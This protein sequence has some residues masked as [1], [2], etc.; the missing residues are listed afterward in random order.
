[1]NTTQLPLPGMAPVEIPPVL[2]I[3]A[4][5]RR[6]LAAFPECGQSWSLTIEWGMK[7]LGLQQT[8]TTEARAIDDEMERVAPLLAEC[9]RNDPPAKRRQVWQAWQETHRRSEALAAQINPAPH[10]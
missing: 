7:Q 9:L 8:W 4:L 10:A 2:R 5:A 1:M 6:C 3:L